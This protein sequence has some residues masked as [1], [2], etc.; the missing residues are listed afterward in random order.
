[1]RVAR[2]AL[3]LV[4]GF[5]CGSNDTGSG[6]GGAGN[7]GPFPD[8]EPLPPLSAAKLTIDG[9]I[10]AA[11]PQA[12]GALNP[13]LP[14]SIATLLAD[15]FGEVTPAPGEPVVP[16]TLD[17]TTPVPPGEGAKVLARFVHL[18]DTQLAD[19]ESP[20]R[21]TIFDSPMGLTSGAFRPQEGYECRILNAAVRTI[22]KIHEASPIDLVVLGGDNA[23]NAQT[24]EVDWF[25]SILEGAPRVE[26]DSGADDDPVRG[27]AN[28]PKDPFFAE[29]L[30]MKWI[31]VTGNH[32]LLNQGNFVTAKLA[33]NYASL[34]A[35]GGS[36]SWAD[37][38]GPVSYSGEGVIPDERRAPLDATT[39][40]EKVKGV[41]DGHGI[42]ADVVSYGRAYYTHDVAGT[43]LRF[44]VVD[45]ASPTGS[46]DGLIL[47]GD[48]T[49][50]VRPALDK[51]LVDGKLVIVTSHHSSN[52]LTDGGGYGGQIH[53]D[54]VLAEEWRDLLGE[55]P[56]VLMH[57]AGHTHDHKVAIISPPGGHAYWEVES[58]ALADYPHQLR[59]VE[60][61]DLAN[62]F[63]GVRLV[64]FDY[65]VEGD[66]VAAQGRKLG[67]IDYTSGWQHDGSG[68][69]AD[70]NVEL[71]V[72]K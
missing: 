18:A 68:T 37:P 10:V 17:G 41:S 42:D 62:G 51:A 47:A 9:R 23:D 43:S 19:D 35:D 30:K 12:A 59:L 28:D 15:G 50:R 45:T 20:A 70:R 5:A 24:N 66:P 56:N 34:L 58:A 40:L 48:V 29:G 69:P 60:V 16:R 27:P 2:L 63:Y 33:A 46:A 54:A 13:Q 39:L 32:D 64:A 44:V 49:A 11:K 57:L 71:Y 3:A 26:C 8:P 25:T 21:V 4:W 14:E 61:R 31:W 38:A 55:Y 7:A 1:M 72:K 22:N 6:G 67:V 36:R 53:A 52:Q 65:E